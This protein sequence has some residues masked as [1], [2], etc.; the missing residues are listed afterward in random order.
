MDCKSSSLGS[1]L[2]L[3]QKAGTKSAISMKESFSFILNLVEIQAPLPME[4]AAGFVLQKATDEQVEKIKEKLRV[5][6]KLWWIYQR[7]FDSTGGEGQAEGMLANLP[8]TAWRY[9][10]VTFD[11]HGADKLSLEIAASLLLNPLRFGFAVTYSEKGEEFTWDP[12]VMADYSC[13]WLSLIR[14]PSLIGENDIGQLRQTYDLLQQLKTSSPAV[15]RS[16]QQFYDLR[17]IPES[18]FFMVIGIFSVIEGLITHAPE[19]TQPMDS[20]TH[21]MKTK[22]NLLS[23]RF[24][25]QLDY[26]GLFETADT[27]RLWGKLYG[28]R[29]KVAHG[30]TADF[31]SDNKKDGFKLLKS[32]TNVLRF[33]NEV[34]K[35]LVL[36][37]MKEPEFISDLKRC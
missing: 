6:G 32:P 7:S 16:A 37:A 24:E 8:P 3:R 14:P 13:N 30:D 27:D 9:W 34:A 29:S 5:F 19:L 10:V 35:L 20:L 23:K 25:R 12:S 4:I 17:H 22:M 31:A 2:P 21:Q 1:A 28:Y 11:G 36:Y 26:S 18:N 15:Y 33:L